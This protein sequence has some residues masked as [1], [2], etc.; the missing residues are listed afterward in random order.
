MQAAAFDVG[1]LMDEA[2]TLRLSTSLDVQRTALLIG[3]LRTCANQA[4]DGNGHGGG[5]A[6]KLRDLANELEQRLLAS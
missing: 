5:I 2:M 1:E 6:L 3:K 4:S